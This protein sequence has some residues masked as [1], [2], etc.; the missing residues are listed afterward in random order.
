MPAKGK[1]IPTSLK[2]NAAS[3]ARNYGDKG[4]IVITVGDEGMRIGVHGLSD[5]EMQ[6]A[7]CVAIH[8]NFCMMESDNL[9]GES[10]SK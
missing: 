10:R 9:G 6:D 1:I 4:A 2:H 3:I 8:Y 5:R 7:L